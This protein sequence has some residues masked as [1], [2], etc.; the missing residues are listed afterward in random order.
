MKGDKLDID[1]YAGVFS[2]RQFM[3]PDHFW[4]QQKYSKFTLPLSYQ[5]LHLVKNSKVE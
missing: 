2:Y 4:K 3:W 5:E 1:V